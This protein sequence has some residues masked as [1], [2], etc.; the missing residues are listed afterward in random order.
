[1]SKSRLPTQNRR[2]NC[3]SV[4]LA[5]P[6]SPQQSQLAAPLAPRSPGPGPGPSPLLPRSAAQSPAPRRP[7]PTPKDFSYLLRPEIYHPLTGLNVPAPF[8]NHLAKQPTPDTPIPELLSR[9][10][11]R[12]AAIAATQALTGPSPPD[13]TDHATIF[14]LLYTRLACLTLIDATALAAQ[15]VRTLEDLNSAFYVDDL[16]GDHLV[17]WEL[18]VLNVRL[19]AMGFGDARR[20]V[21]SY[22]DLA[23]EA[24]ARL[25]KAMAD[26]DNS[27]RE[28]WKERLGDIGVRVAGALVEMGDLGGAAAHLMSL[29]GKDV[30]KL[31]MARALLWLQLGDVEMAR[32]CIAGEAGETAEKVVAALCDMADGEYANALARWREVREEVDDEMIGVNTAV[33]LLYVGK[34]QEVSYLGRRERDVVD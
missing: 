13:P 32:S 6:L 23:R 18:R 5:S 22:Y 30:G 25:A 4:P 15:E 8:R 16:S 14:S 3:S 2:L 27:A 28:L 11:F 31:A 21:M 33:C 12:A 20:A 1:M 24:R 17:P 29:P 34:M 7:P 10:Q 26:H 19:Q 9:G